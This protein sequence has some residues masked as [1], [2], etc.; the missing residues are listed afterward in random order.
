[1]NQMLTIPPQQ[2]QRNVLIAQQQVSILEGS[3]IC[4]IKQKPFMP[5]IF[6]AL[7]CML[8]YCVRDFQNKS[9]KGEN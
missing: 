2:Q 1:M 7:V 6:I 5:M 4:T 8:L 9:I 3:I